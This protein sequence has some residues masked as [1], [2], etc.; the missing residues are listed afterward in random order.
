MSRCKI[1]RTDNLDKKFLY[2]LMRKKTTVFLTLLLLFS[3]FFLIFEK[4][5]AAQ[6]LQFKPFFTETADEVLA[7][8][9]LDEKIGQILIFGFWGDS[10]DENFQTW[11]TTGELGNIKIFLRNVE[12]GEQLQGLTNLVIALAAE[13]EYGIPPFIATDMEGG[14]VNHIRFE[15]IPLA[16]S[17]GLIGASGNFENARNTARLIALTLLEFGINMNFAPVVDILTNPENRVISTRSYGSDPQRVY[18]FSKI[19]IQEHEKLGIITVLKH[20]PG[21]GMTSFDSHLFSDSVDI[22]REDLF[23]VHILP[24]RKL[25]REG[26]TGGIMVSHIIYND[27][28]PEYPAAFSTVVI[29]NLLREEL[30]YDGLV[31]TD[32][33]EMEGSQGYA[34]DIV[35]AF[36]LAF[37]AGNDLLLVAHTEKFQ[38]KLLD[39][40][41]GLF[42]NGTL[43][44]DALDQKVLRVLKAKKKYLSRFYTNMSFEKE[45]ET[46]LKQSAEIVEKASNEGIVL[47]TSNIEGSIPD[48][49]KL[50]TEKNQKGLILSPNSD[51]TDN[52]KKHLPDWEVLDI[53]SFPERELNKKRAKEAQHL[54]KKY[55]IIILGFTSIRQ[56]EWAE[57]CIQENIPFAILSINNPLTPMRFADYTLFLATSF[58]PHSPATDA[59]YK[60]VF[61]TGVFTGIFPYHFDEIIND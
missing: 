9:S 23:N 19:F 28:D 8:M 22:S 35:D 44:E 33:L 42:K 21:H 37:R 58:G 32:D 51:F 52:V 26:K 50:T 16:P 18:E 2:R 6:T 55:D 20:F 49:F 10:L 4:T 47:L 24:Y 34:K 27:I 45:H 36:I 46:A 13:S 41:A 12:T 17:A 48:Y 14:T 30:K 53:G 60:N 56:I 40:A 5:K 57:A 39:T 7:Q 54:L 61:E 59:L 3:S 43:S 31:I 1:Q 11:L 38:K 15:G 29:N 25:I